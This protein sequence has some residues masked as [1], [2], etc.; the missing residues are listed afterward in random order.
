MPSFIRNIKLHVVVSLALF[1]ASSALNAST[2]Y[3]KQSG[4]DDANNGSSWA[5]SLNTFSKALEIAET[6][7]SI[8]AIWLA[9]GTYGGS[10]NNT[11]LAAGDEQ[12]SSVF[13][14]SKALEIY[15]GFA[16]TE[17]SL[18]KRSHGGSSPHDT[19]AGHPTN[20]T[21]IQGAAGLR[22]IYLAVANIE[23]DGITFS[24]GGA[25]VAPVPGEG[26]G[27]YAK[28]GATLWRCKVKNN[29][30]QGDG[31]GIYVSAGTFNV[32]WTEIKSN[33]SISG[34]GGGVYTSD[35]K[36]IGI[37]TLRIGEDFGAFTG[38]EHILPLAILD[39]DVMLLMNP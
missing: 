25:S 5:N 2:L 11:D 15:G 31:G 3:V 39:R 6:N 37:V 30:A 24:R 22:P 17:D 16:G 38:I 27:V 34:S 20:E 32:I 35:G 26:G 13:T 4:G 19:F 36:Y 7:A 10:D 29:F 28:S 18:D 14:I 9:K 1:L 21:I 8:K 23:L 12:S 33:T